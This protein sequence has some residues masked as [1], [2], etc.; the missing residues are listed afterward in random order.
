MDKSFEYCNKEMI[1]DRNI[2]EFIGL[3]KGVLADNEFNELEKEF[4]L[5]W[6]N[7]ND[8]SKH[9]IVENIFNELS[10]NENLDE[11]KS[12]LISFTGGS[13]PSTEINSMSTALPIEKMIST[14][15]FDNTIFCLTGKFSS[16]Y[17]NRKAIEE[18]IEAKKGVCK[19]RLTLDVNYLVIGELGNSDWKHSTL[20]RKIETALLY[21]KESKSN[22]KII[23]EEQL[24]R[25]L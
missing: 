10:H 2:D 5:N 7:S 17:G 22:I 25:D 4:L 18:I 14:I 20:G 21:K 3:C 13:T 16:A 23:S 11:L 9:V 6:L 1:N 12:I 19:K 15:K 8:L 24:L